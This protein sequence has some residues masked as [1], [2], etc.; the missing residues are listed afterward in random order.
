M[1]A[2][3][4]RVSGVRLLVP[5]LAGFMFLLC[6]VS[7]ASSFPFR[8]ISK[9]DPLPGSLVFRNLGDG[10]T[11][12]VEDLKGAPAVLVFW[13]ADMESKKKRSLKTFKALEEILPYLRERKIR[14]LLVNAQGDSTDVMQDVVG[15]L[16]G[17]MPAYADET[18]RAYGALGIFVVPS[19]LLSDGDGNVVAGLGYSHDFSERLKGEV[20]VML[21]E[22]TRADVEKELRPEMKEK[23][24]GEKQATRHFNMALVM[25]KRGQTD[26]A[27]SELNKALELEP[28]MGE[29]HGQ[30]G[31]L[32]LEQG[33]IGEARAALD[34]SYDLN[35]EYLPANICDALL[36]AEEGEAEDA[37]GDL[38]SLLFRHARNPELHYALGRLHEK[39]GKSAEAAQEYRKAFELIFRHVEY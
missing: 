1:R 5:G 16:D 11:L 2:F 9:G 27:I 8:A 36:R 39:Q 15:S 17:S 33:K 26:S 31:C 10:S 38:Q 30:L 19:V 20:E 22:K 4:V 23:P 13:G 24:A 18:Q 7:M 35:P 12:T 32:Y 37:L 14:V 21:G 3:S 28:D 6:S 29:A 34:K 25:Q